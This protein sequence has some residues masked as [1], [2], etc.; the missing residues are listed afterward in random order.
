MGRVI[1]ERM[2]VDDIYTACAFGDADRAAALVGADPALAAA[3]SGPDHPLGPGFVP[4]IMAASRGFAGVVRALLEGGADPNAIDRRGVTA[5]HHA[6]GEGN[7]ELVRLLL[8]RGANPHYR[9]ENWESTALDWAEHEGHTEVAA[10]LRQA[11][12]RK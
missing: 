6:A 3:R 9:D 11:M 8:E 4:I 1:A 2:G 5:L 12:A 7:A 10:T